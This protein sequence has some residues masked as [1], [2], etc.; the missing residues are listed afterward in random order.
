MTEKTN[1]RCLCG[2][3]EFKISGR[4]PHLYQCHCSLC[5][6]LSGSSSDTATFLDSAQFAWVKGE[7]LVNSFVTETGYRSDF[8]SKCGSTVPHLMTNQKQY[9]IP[10]GLLDQ[11]KDSEVVAHLFVGSKASW[12]S[13]CDSGAQYDTM[14]DMDTLNQA[15]QRS[16]R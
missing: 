10:A 12:D 1:G 9:W 15:L 14:P 6:K 4:L 7:A 2:E 8:C 11:V 16:R 13:V 5:R 3:V